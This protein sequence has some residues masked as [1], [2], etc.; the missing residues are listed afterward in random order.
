MSTML[1][2][3]SR[4]E[5]KGRKVR[6][7]GKVP[8]VVYG[9]DIPSTPIAI[10]ELEFLKTLKEAGKNGIISLS[11]E[12]DTYEV[13]THDIQKEK[14][15]GDILHIDFYKVD[16]S[17]KMDANVPIHL[18]GEAMGVTDGGVIQQTL[19]EVSVR[20][21][22]ADIPESIQI[23][24]SDMMIGD[25]LQVRDLPKSGTYEINNEPEEGI[26]SIL[27]PTL[28]NEPDEQQEKE[29]KEEVQAEKENTAEEE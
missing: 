11:T 28:A 25:S 27:A 16:M 3:T 8:A 17:S 13:I 10:N 5:L 20:S 22:P 18:V 24:I 29:D 21:L 9:K 14:L 6:K 1:K 26:M 19:Y 7:Q 4:D 2:A 12:G 23:D 15:R